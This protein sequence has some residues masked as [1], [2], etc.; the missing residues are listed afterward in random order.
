[1]SDNPRKLIYY[2]DG[3]KHS[4]AAIKFFSYLFKNLANEVVVFTVATT[5]PAGT[6]H[7]LEK[8]KA[9]LKKSGCKN[10]SYKTFSG[11]AYNVIKQ[12][13][14][15]QTNAI[16]IRSLPEMNPIIS[17]ISEEDVDT[18]GRKIINNLRN[19]LLLVKN[20][21]KKIR[22]VLICTDGSEEAEA[23]I[24]LLADLKLKPQP[25]I[26]ILNVIPATFSFFESYLETRDRLDALVKIKNKRTKVLFNAREILAKQGLR[27][28]IKI[29]IGD[30]TEEVLK[31]AA[32][33]FDL[34]V[35]G[36]RGRKVLR[37]KTLG[38]HAQQ[39]LVRAKTSVL[40]V[41]K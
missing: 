1:M 37:K 26:K 27:S 9:E 14:E 20:P 3:G 15:A 8:A 23:A 17:E 40:I 33:D 28:K 21:P 6:E 32:G 30:V 22:K 2:D 34:I 4:Q 19:S 13:I 29:R 24:H 11:P 39:V 12:E 10:V 41:K 31:E 38:R 7:Y 16:L 5:S 25:Q 36:L 35:M 18:L